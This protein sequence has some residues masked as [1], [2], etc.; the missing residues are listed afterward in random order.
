MHDVAG[1][2]RR[3]L[4]RPQLRIVLVDVLDGRRLR[5]PCGRSVRTGRRVLRACAMTRLVIKPDQRATTFVELADGTQVTVEALIDMLDA[6]QRV[7][8][9]DG[10]EYDRVCWC[11][12]HPHELRMGCM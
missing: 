9:I 6:A 11:G 4:V 3:C 2:P 7:T 12:G 8:R 1:V 10:I 5:R